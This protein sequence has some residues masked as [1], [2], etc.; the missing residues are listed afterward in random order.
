MSTQKNKDLELEEY[1]FTGYCKSKNQTN[2]VTCEYSAE[3]FGPC[4]ERIIGCD[5]LECQYNKECDIVKQALAK[6]DE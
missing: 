2:L 1:F 5:Y 6:E 3:E 4:L